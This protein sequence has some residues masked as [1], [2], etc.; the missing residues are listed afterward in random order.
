[1]RDRSTEDIERSESSRDTGQNSDRKTLKRR[2]KTKQKNPWPALKTQAAISG[3]HSNR[4]ARYLKWE[5]LRRHPETLTRATVT[6]TNES[7]FQSQRCS[8]TAMELGEKQEGRETMD[9]TLES[10]L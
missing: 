2:K 9:I 5:A 6:R 10:Y 1:M 7:P 3:R 8:W 4:R